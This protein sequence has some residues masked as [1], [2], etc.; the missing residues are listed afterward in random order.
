MYAAFAEVPKPAD[1][2]DTLFVSPGNHDIY[3][4]QWSCFRQYFHT[5]SY[6]FLVQTPS[7][8]LDFYLIIDSAEGCLGE[9]QLAWLKQIL[10]W[11]DK[12]PFRH[13][14]VAT[15]THPFMEDASQ[16]LTSNYPLEET[17][18]LVDLFGSHHV[19]FYLCG[20]D[21]YRDVTRFGGCTY[22]VLDALQD[23]QE[24]AGYMVM[25]VS[26]TVNYDFVSVIRK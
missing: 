4:D 18:E 14:M 15:H 10:S 1:K 7:G 22:I 9:K 5:S 20:H 19:E 23:K 11:A 2:K 24:N 17:Y 26:S 6:Y 13:R 3:F 21:H 25:D 12:Q 16:E 8:K